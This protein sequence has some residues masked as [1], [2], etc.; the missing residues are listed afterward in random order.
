VPD[1]RG[2]GDHAGAGPR[3]RRALWR[4]GVSEPQ[5][6]PP[7]RGAVTAAVVRLDARIKSLLE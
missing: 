3:P 4:S 1:G 5:R 2:D 6:P 7:R